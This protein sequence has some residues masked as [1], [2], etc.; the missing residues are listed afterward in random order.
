MPWRSELRSIR[1]WSVRVIFVLLVAFTAVLVWLRISEALGNPYRLYHSTDR[2]CSSIGFVEGRFVIHYDGGPDQGLI[3]PRDWTFMGVSWKG[4]V[5]GGGP[6]W[7]QRDIR[8]DGWFAVVLLGGAWLSAAWSFIVVP[9]LRRRRG[10][11]TRCA[12]DLRD[13]RSSVCPECGLRI[14]PPGRSSAA[15][16]PPPGT[17]SSPPRSQV[18]SLPP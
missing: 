11:C 1:W 13:T 10:R 6:G 3:T 5:G 7:Q 15:I 17:A 14:A 18:Q 4:G 16:P 9:M 12:Y 8:L 2:F